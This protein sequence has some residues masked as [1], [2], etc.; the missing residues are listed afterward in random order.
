MWFNF[1]LTVEEN[2][3]RR[4]DSL[5]HWTWWRCR[6]L[7]NICRVVLSIGFSLSIHTW[8]TCFQL[9]FS[10]GKSSH[11]IVHCK[12]FWF[13]PGPVRSLLVFSLDHQT[14]YNFV[15]VYFSS[16]SLAIFQNNHQVM[17]IYPQFPKYMSFSAYLHTFGPTFPL[18]ATTMP[19]FFVYMANSRLS[20]ETQLLAVGLNASF[21]GPPAVLKPWLYVGWVSL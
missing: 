9:V 11:R 5:S 20:S 15:S 2:K 7:A 1:C 14:I 13:F 18:L 6:H 17:P 8:A 16:S 12:I 19:N 4:T 10:S 3:L 21:S